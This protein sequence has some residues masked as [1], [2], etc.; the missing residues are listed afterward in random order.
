MLSTTIKKYLCK[1]RQNLKAIKSDR[2]PAKY[3]QN[4]KFYAANAGYFGLVV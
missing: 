4:I 3:C 1:T 2:I